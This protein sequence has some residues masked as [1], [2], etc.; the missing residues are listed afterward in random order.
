M[1]PTTSDPTTSDAAPIDLDNPVRSWRITKSRVLIGIVVVASLA[2]WF[3]AFVLAS[4]HMI[5]RMDDRT[6][7]T[8]AEPV[9]RATMDQ[10]KQLPKTSPTPAERATV[11]RLSNDMLHGMTTGLR[12]LVPTEN[13]AG[14][15]LWIDHWNTYIQDRAD[16]ADTLAALPPGG[17]A[18]FT[19]T[20]IDGVQITRSI[21]HFAEV[22]TMASCETPGD[23]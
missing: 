16:F 15:N 3:Y 23:V 4:P 12:T 22:N 17:D 5:D 19:E 8:A 14:I 1:T 2:L 9:C 7:P 18:K 6:F 11:L 20:G 21:D 10:L 13:A